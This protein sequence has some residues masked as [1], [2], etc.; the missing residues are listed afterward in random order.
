MFAGR[1]MGAVFPPVALLHSGPGSYEVYL[2]KTNA[3][4]DTLWTRTCGRSGDEYCLGL[5]LTDDGGCILVGSSSSPTP[6]VCEVFIV[7]TAA[8]GDSSWMR[9]YVSTGNDYGYCVG[10]TA[11]GGYMV[12]GTLYMTDAPN[13]SV[14]G[15]A[16]EYSVRHAGR[17]RIAIDDWP[18]RKVLEITDPRAGPGRHTAHWDSRDPAGRELPPGA[19]IAEP[20]PAAS[21][22]PV[23]RS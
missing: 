9:H 13:P 16:T 19:L 23:C 15:I 3:D 21:P 12:S 14:G 2:V 4:G 7:K 20:G 5:D 10:Q 22:P 11:G 17:V 18:G 1:A 6:S 8:A